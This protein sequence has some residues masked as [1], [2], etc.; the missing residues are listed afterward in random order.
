[1]SESIPSRV[2][3]I[4]SG[5]LNAVIDAVENAAPETVMREAIREVEKA[6]EEVRAELGKII[7]TKHLATTKLMNEN[8]KHA[9][10]A[11]K[12]ELAIQENRDDLAEVAIAAQLN[13]E[14]QLPILETTIS[15]NASKEKEL[16]GYISALKAKKLE[17]EAEIDEFLKAQV[18]AQSSYTNAQTNAS[19]AGP[20]ANIDKATSAFDR[21]LKNATGLHSSSVN[22][23]TASA[24]QMAE[25]DELNRKNRIQERLAEIKKSKG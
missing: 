22:T 15:D 17:M 23:D 19:N 12:I 2:S 5:S 10:L 16:E 1:M 4:I 18:E 6:I 14:A 25:L 7:A 9:D 13:I 20:S 3:R 24:K 8:Q 11:E 21:V